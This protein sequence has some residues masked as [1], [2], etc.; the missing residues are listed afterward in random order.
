MSPC[1]WC[2]EPS[3]ARVIVEPAVE[4]TEKTRVG[5]ERVVVKRAIE[6][7]ACAEHRDMVYREA[8]RRAKR[9]SRDGLRNPP[10]PLSD[11]QE[12]RLATLERELDPRVLA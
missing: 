5:Q 11:A 10:R 6:A 3:V 8:D 7:D 12:Y 2:G 4:K 9:A 1:Q